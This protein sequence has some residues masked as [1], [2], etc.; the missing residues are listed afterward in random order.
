MR[1][2]ATLRVLAALGVALIAAGCGGSSDTSGN[3]A[4]VVIGPAGRAD[5]YA[6]VGASETVGVG[7]TDQP[8]RLRVAWPQLFYNEALDRAA[9]YYNFGVPGITTGDA[10][11]RELP[12]ALAVHPTVV[13]V[14]LGVDDLA[15]GAPAATYEANLDAL[16]HALTQS[17]RA[18]VLVANTP[19]LEG[20]PAFRACLGDA[21]AGVSC[22]VPGGVGGVNAATIDSLVDA[23]NAATARVV[24]REG[25]VL[26]D[27]HSASYDL[28]AH[29]EYIGA[30]GLHPSPLGHAALARLFLAAY[31]QHPRS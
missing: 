20:L 15:R 8:L 14:F 6:A 17:G 4:T 9:T 26:V 13:S 18:I 5:V 22:P 23:Y 16:A 21:S 11:Q 29:P 10:L 31:R 30:D 1:P 12:A 27:L 3:G 28:A 19:R 7:L 25:A 2:V 24:S